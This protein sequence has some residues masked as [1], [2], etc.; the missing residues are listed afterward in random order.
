MWNN[1]I[2]QHIRRTNRTLLAVNGGIVI[3]LCA[4]AL[5][6]GRYLF[7]FILGPFPTD[8][9]TLVSI[10]DPNQTFDYY[11]TIDGKVIPP[12]IGREVEQR[13]NKHTK[14]VESETVKAEYAVASISNRLLVIKFPG[15]AD[16]SQQQFT[17]TLVPMP[18]DMWAKL[19]QGPE[20]K[21]HGMD[22]VFLPY[23]LDATGFRTPGWIGLGIGLPLYVL[24]IWNVTRAIR[25]MAKVE[26]HPISQGLSRFGTPSEVAAG[27]DAEVKELIRLPSGKVTLTRSWLLNSSTFGL[28][29]FHVNELVWIYKKVTKHSV[30][31]VPTGSTYAAMIHTRYGGSLEVPAAHLTDGLLQ[32]LVE[33]APWVLCGFDEQLAGYWK[34]DPGGVVAAVDDRRRQVLGGEVEDVQPAPAEEESPRTRGPNHRRIEMPDTFVRLCEADV[35]SLCKS[36]VC[37]K[38]SRLRRPN[39]SRKR[40]VVP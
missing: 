8:R 40:T 5:L 38:S 33:R 3:V 32:Q 18:G 13:I 10:A 28:E 25:R 2:G 14:K 35:Y 37:G 9:K 19:T 31:F 1:I 15:R 22:E 34:S 4:L 6:N 24:C 11:V 29:V 7:N 16:A 26:R 23:M 20:N 39:N 27:I 12:A 21:K 17:G 36:C 30:N